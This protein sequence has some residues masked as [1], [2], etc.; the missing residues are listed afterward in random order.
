MAFLIEQYPDCGAYAAAFD[1][2]SGDRI[3]SNVHPAQ[4][5]IVPDF[6]GR[7]CVPIFAS[8][9]QRSFRVAFSGARGF[10]EGMKIGEDLYFW[11]RL[12]SRYRICF[13]PENL[14]LYSRT[15]SN[16]SAGIYT[17]ERTVY[18]FEDLYCP[19]EENSFRNEYIARC[20][21]G[22]A[23][24]LSAKGDTAFGLRTERFSPIRECIGAGG[25]NFV[26]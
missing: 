20:A 16:R 10:P 8:P 19:Q 24:T 12:A 6:S 18:S 22:K 25:G 23:L 2:V 17:P 21:I 3:Y 13:T 14:V 9:R 1:I 7:R 15:A 11:I 26:F 5:G 4:E